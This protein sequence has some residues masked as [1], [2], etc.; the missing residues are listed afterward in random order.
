MVDNVLWDELAGSVTN[1]FKVQGFE[2][3][4]WGDWGG[5]QCRGQC[6]ICDM[7]W[8]CRWVASGKTQTN[9]YE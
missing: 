8:W 5:V 4:C 7:A 6:I 9:W 2:V 3:D 1:L